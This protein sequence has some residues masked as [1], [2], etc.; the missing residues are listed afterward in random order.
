MEELKIAFALS[1][2]RNIDYIASLKRS[3]YVFLAMIPNN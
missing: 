2:K 1:I 3:H